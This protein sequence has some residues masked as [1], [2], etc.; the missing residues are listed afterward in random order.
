MTYRSPGRTAVRA[1]RAAALHADALA[2][3]DTGGDAHLHLARAHLDA[4]ARGTSGTGRG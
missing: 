2:V 1:G 4:A 3:G